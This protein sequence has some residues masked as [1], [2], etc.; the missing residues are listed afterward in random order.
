[1]T[2]WNTVSFSNYPGKLNSKTNSKPCEVSVFWLG[3]AGFLIVFP[4]ARI[5]IDPYLSNYLAKKYQGK[6][7]PHDRMMPVPIAANKLKNLDFVFCTHS[8][9]D[10]MDPETLPVLMQN[11]PN[12]KLI[13]PKAEEKKVEEMSISLQQRMPVDAGA[14]IA[15]NHSLQCI[16]IASAHEELETDKDGYHRFLGYVLKDQNLTLYHSG[17]CIPYSGLLDDLKTKNIHL[18]LLPVNGRD[19]RRRKNN[20]PGNFTIEEAIDLCDQSDIPYMIGHHH[21]MFAFNTIS[22]EQA[23]KVIANHGG[24]VGCH[25]SSL[26]TKY[27]LASG[28]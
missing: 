4:E 18:A 24:K 27:I 10:H 26:N 22:P 15:L 19:E 25:M 16:T 6:K 8:H 7:F 3:Q 12:A 28:P 21:G 9:S 13:F 1:M 23:E 17:D 2:A 5:A 11:N 14:S 20:I